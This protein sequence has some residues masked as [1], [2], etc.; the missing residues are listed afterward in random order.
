[1]SAITGTG[2][3]ARILRNDL[4]ASTSGTATRTI[5]HPS[6]VSDRI[7]ASVARTSRV[8]VFV[9]LWTETG[10]P[11]PTGTPPTRMRRVS[12]RVSMA[13]ITICEIRKGRRFP[14]SSP[15]PRGG[16]SGGSSLGRFLPLPDLRSGCG[17]RQGAELH[18]HPDP[19]GPRG[20]I[21][22]RSVGDDFVPLERWHRTAAGRI[23]AL[24]CFSHGHGVLSGGIRTRPQASNVRHA[25]GECLRQHG[26]GSVGSRPRDVPGNGGLPERDGPFARRDGG[27]GNDVH[28]CRAEEDQE[29]HRK[30]EGAPPAGRHGCQKTAFERCV[31]RTTCRHGPSPCRQQH[32]TV[33]VFSAGISASGLTCQTR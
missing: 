31:T 2:D 15:F 10:A 11:P 18:I 33:T 28:P 19:G 32:Q 25:I 30:D 24:P 8:S 6:R 12:L 5:S 27:T 9:M 14:F 13:K 16:C 4:A 17:G 21:L 1:M 23:A 29:E 20:R 26:D 7:W 22:D 3:P